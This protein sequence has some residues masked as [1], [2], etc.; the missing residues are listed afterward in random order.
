MGQP[1]IW[2]ERRGNIGIIKLNRVDELNALD[3]PTLTE[4]GEVID[5][6]YQDSKDIRVVV[7][8]RE[9]RAFC[10]SADL[11]ERRTLTP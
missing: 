8:S 1:A 3:F 5:E 7:V 9:G 10:V 4:L 11:K 6:L 2:F